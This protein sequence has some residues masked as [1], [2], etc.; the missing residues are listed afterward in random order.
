MENPWIYAAIT[1]QL[2]K[3]VLHGDGFPVCSTKDLPERIGM[4]VESTILVKILGFIERK[5]FI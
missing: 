5:F 2:E 3:P 4:I 1:S